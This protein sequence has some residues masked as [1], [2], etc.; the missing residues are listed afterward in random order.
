MEISS[1]LVD[2]LVDQ[3]VRQIEEKAARTERSSG[4]TAAASWSSP[5]L[6]NQRERHGLFR[7]VNEAVAA[8][9]AAFS[10]WMALPRARKNEIIQKMRETLLDHAKE[11]SEM[12]VRETGLGRVEDK[13]QKNRLVILKTPGTEILTPRMTTGDHGSEFIDYVPYG[14]IC[15]ISPTTNPSETIINNGIGMIAAG[16]TVVFNPHPSAREVSGKTVT[17]MN[18]VI[19]SMGGPA[20]V[21]CCVDKPT[22]ESAGELMSHPDTALVVVTGGPAVVKAAMRTGKKVMAAGPGNPPAVVDETCDIDHAA[23]CLVRGASLDNNV[24][25]IVEKEI[26]VLKSVA[27]SLKASMCRH[28]AVMLTEAQRDRLENIIV[29]AD[30]HVNK[31]F[32]GKDAAVILREIGVNVPPQTRLVICDA[33]E[34]HAFVQ[35]ELL[36][37]VIPIV[38]VDTFDEAIQMAKRVE[39]G[40]RHTAVI[41]S[42]NI[43]RIHRMGQLM[44]CSLFIANAPSF[45]GLGLEGEGYTSF[46]IASPTGEGLTTARNF[47][48]ERRYTFAGHFNMT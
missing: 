31:K 25:C 22:I 10:K 45:A 47:S 48:R 43:D 12:A 7:T 4:T 21:L 30:G 13:I 46:T 17:I 27:E 8:A 24:V 36:M 40:F 14:V 39:H 11:L 1:D 38:T 15:S 33:T 20:H 37:P 2:K 3:V 42:K 35:L 32:V 44:N 9:K 5:A 18:Q 23:K 19:Q 26:I 16:N 29:T 6:G 41:H 34:K 28:G